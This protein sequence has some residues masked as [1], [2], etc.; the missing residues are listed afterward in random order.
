MDIADF[1]P[2]KFRGSGSWELSSTPH[3]QKNG[4]KAKTASAIED[5]DWTFKVSTQPQ[6]LFG[7]SNGKTT[8]TLFTNGD[9]SKV[10]ETFLPSFF[11]EKNGLW[12]RMGKWVYLNQGNKANKTRRYGQATS[13]DLLTLIFVECL[14]KE[15]SRLRTFCKKYLDVD[16]LPKVILF[17]GQVIYPSDEKT[18]DCGL[19]KDFEQASKALREQE[20]YRTE[21]DLMLLFKDALCFIE[22]KAGSRIAKATD[23]YKGKE[24]KKCSRS[25]T[26]KDFYCQGN[27]ENFPFRQ[28][29]PDNNFEPLYEIFRNVV[30]GRAVAK[31]RLGSES[32]FK[33][34]TLTPSKHANLI[35]GFNLRVKP[36]AAVKALY[37]EEIFADEAVYPCKSC[38]GCDK[39]PH[40]EELVNRLQF[41]TDGFANVVVQDANHHSATF[42]L[43]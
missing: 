37:W 40:R 35:D 4:S 26:E 41:T 18:A 25:A 33:M 11:L 6:P 10:V 42:T 38:H 3:L 36:E 13:E 16:E 30:L 27:W 23:I 20:K 9:C 14:I 15:P 29:P 5:C 12:D 17:G 31:Q 24:S 19:R 28:V 32:K 8:K 21:P 39:C 34:F 1:I 43:K 22:V 7:L 2:E